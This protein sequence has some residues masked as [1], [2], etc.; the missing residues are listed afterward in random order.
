MAEIHL[1]CPQCHSNIVARLQSEI[2]MEDRNVPRMSFPQLD[3]PAPVKQ[4]VRPQSFEKIVVHNTDGTT[5]EVTQFD[6]LVLLFL[7]LES[8]KKTVK[9][10]SDERLTQE[11]ERIQTRIKERKEQ[12]SEL[13]RGWRGLARTLYLEK[14]HWLLTEE[15]ERRKPAS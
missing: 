4:R 9:G 6:V 10:Y 8:H 15:Q 11:I 2:F 14:H 3:V 5:R 12:R 7:E 1:E 13:L